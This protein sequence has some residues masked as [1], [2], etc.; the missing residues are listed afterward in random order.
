M[1][2]VVEW[3]QARW[4]WLVVGVT[5]GLLCFL[6]TLTVESC[7]KHRVD[8]A[9]SE[10]VDAGIVATKAE[11]AAGVKQSFVGPLTDA[12]IEEQERA[13]KLKEEAEKRQA[14]YDTLR[15]AK[16]SIDDALDLLREEM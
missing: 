15:N 2:L 5:C 10:A 14:E 1:N 9:L 7:R 6:V 11:V 13:R 8:K 3:L 4:R 16:V 12:A